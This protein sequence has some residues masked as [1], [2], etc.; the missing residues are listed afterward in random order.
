MIGLSAV[1]IECIAGKFPALGQNIVPAGNFR[2]DPQ[3]RHRRADDFHLPGY[4]VIFQAHQKRKIQ[5][6]Q[7]VENRPTTGQAPGKM[8]TLLF[9]EGGSALF[10][11]ILIAAND[12]RIPVLPQIQDTLSRFY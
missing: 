8:A 11:R 9:Q 4:T 5:I 6:P 1:F 7:I 2:R 3:A 12:H 10:P